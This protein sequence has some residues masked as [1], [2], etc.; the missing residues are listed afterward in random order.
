MQ[1]ASRRLRVMNTGRTTSRRPRNGRWRGPGCARAS[2]LR[3]LFRLDRLDNLTLLEVHGRLA[4]DRFVALQSGLDVDRGAEVPADRHLLKVQLVFRAHDRYAG[5]LRVE[6]DRGR[7]NPP[8]STG[9]TDL[10]ADVDEHS[11]EHPVRLVRD[12][13]LREQGPGARIER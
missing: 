8:V 2:A 12:I 9:G 10:E 4:H 5:A 11:G 13:D 7:G 3:H 6:D 1:P